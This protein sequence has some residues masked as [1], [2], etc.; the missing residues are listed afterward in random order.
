M[1]AV[2]MLKMVIPIKIHITANKR[3]KIVEG[4]RSPYLEK[5]EEQNMK[6]KKKN[7]WKQ[8]LL[9]FSHI[10]VPSDKKILSCTL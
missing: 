2:N 1:V 5:Q 8:Q 3:P 10:Y 4:V 6:T 7:S 9:F